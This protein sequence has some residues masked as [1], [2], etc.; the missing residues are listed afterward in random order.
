MD[1]AAATRHRTTPPRSRWRAA[2]LSLLP[3]ITVALWLLP[4]PAHAEIMATASCERSPDHGCVEI[5]VFGTDRERVADVTVTLTSPTGESA[6][7][8]S[9]ASGPVVFQTDTAEDYTAVLD[10]A[11]LP[12]AFASATDLERTLTVQFGSTAR[13]TFD[14][15]TAAPASPRASASATPADDPSA[16]T[17]TT[18]A[19]RSALTDRT[20]QQF[21]S[22]LRFGL[23]LALAAVGANLIYGTTRLSNFAHGEQ[24][25]LGAVVTFLLVQVGLPL[26]AAGTIAVALCAA[27]GWL[28]DAALWHPLRKRGTPITQVMIVTIGL[29][30][31]LQFLIQFLVG[32]GTFQV[33]TGN[34]TTFT[35]GPVT[36]TTMSYLAMGISVVVLTSLAFFLTRTRLGRATRA[37]SD[38]PALAAATGINPNLVIRLVWTLAA[39]LAGLAGLLFALMYGAANWNMGLQVLLLMF[40]AITLG[41]LGTAWGAL[42]G[43]LIIGLAVEMSSLLIPSD[44]RYATALFILIIV[45]L[46]RPQGILGLRDRIG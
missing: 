10:P 1:E 38:N 19:S 2:L 13:G 11:T 40:A 45:L 7:A 5:N 32:T 23:M 21:A 29:S 4:T 6:D 30:I 41:G 16:T 9:T 37:V 35:L 15:T 22:G 24:V 17:P 25:T 12:T 43:S 31:A 26:L 28:Q 44:L 18:D 33:V 36:M 3:L 27:T 39:G 42:A 14:L 34:P 46:A 8:A 20:I